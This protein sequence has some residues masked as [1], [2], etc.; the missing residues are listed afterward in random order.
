MAYTQYLQ[1]FLYLHQQYVLSIHFP[2]AYICKCYSSRGTGNEMMKRKRFHKED[3][4]ELGLNRLAEAGGD[5]LRLK[6]LCL[7][8]ER[9]I[10]SF[11]HHFEDQDAFFLAMMKHWR[12]TNS[13]NVIQQIDALPDDDIKA[14]RLGVVAR[15]M[16]QAIE[17][18]VRNF[19][20]QNAMAAVMVVE[21]DEER[22]QYLS[23]LLRMRFSMSDTLARN[24]A[25]LEYAAFVG[26]QSIWGNGG[27]ERG[28]TLSALF[29]R[30]VDK[31]LKRND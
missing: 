31:F 10:G 22:I 5:A 8:A 9:T 17:I 25:E 3:W 11:Y 12:Q 13:Q 28:Q 14:E 4:L 6:D 21:V 29:D 19:A 1:D 7:A 2:D 20:R 27:I 18:G 26:T 24:L 23:K 15:T 30:M 16:D